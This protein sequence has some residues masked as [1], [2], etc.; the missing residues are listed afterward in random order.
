[1]ISKHFGNLE[2]NPTKKEMQEAFNTIDELA[3]LLK[4]KGFKCCVDKVRNTRKF[5]KKDKAA[6]Y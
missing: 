3:P 6:S 4:V 5:L 2:K 1:M